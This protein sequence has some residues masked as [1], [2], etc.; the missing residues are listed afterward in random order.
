MACLHPFRNFNADADAQALHKAMKGIGCDEDE[1]IVILAHRTVQQRK[2][3][4]VSYKAQYGRDLKEQLKKELRGDFE[5]VVLWSF[6]SPPQVN[7]AALKKAM[8][9]AGTNEDMLIDVICTADNREIDEIKTAF[10]ESASFLLTE[11]EFVLYSGQS[12]ILIRKS[13][14]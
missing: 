10:Q 3:I 13:I 8:K 12:R 14:I 5:H 7:A 9:G 4:E 11:I 2:E 6:L 1:I